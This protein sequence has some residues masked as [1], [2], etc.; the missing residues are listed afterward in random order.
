[1]SCANLTECHFFVQSM[2]HRDLETQGGLLSNHLSLSWDH[3]S[4]ILTNHV[5]FLLLEFSTVFQP[6]DVQKLNFSFLVYFSFY[7]LS[8]DVQ[9]PHFFP[10][11][12]FSN[13]LLTTVVSRNFC[14]TWCPGADRFSA[15]FVAD[16]VCANIWCLIIKLKKKRFL[17]ITIVIVL[18]TISNINTIIRTMSNSNT[19]SWVMVTIVILVV[20]IIIIIISIRCQ[21]WR[22]LYLV[23][24]GPHHKFIEGLF[25]FSLRTW[26]DQHL[27]DLSSL[28]LLSIIS[29]HQWSKISDWSS[30]IN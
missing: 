26:R 20:F 21:L 16:S 17:I 23:L 12:F 11:V 27:Q 28:L 7:F 22:L 1:M 19:I 8:P 24:I 6:H 10:G 14:L 2:R 30:M 15:L 5:F 9:E 25:W 18:R 29:N 3:C 13:C 4:L